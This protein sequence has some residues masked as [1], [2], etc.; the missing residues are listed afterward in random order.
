MAGFDFGFRHS[1]EQADF[2]DVCLS[3]AKSRAR[4]MG[5]RWRV[6][7]EPEGEIWCTVDGNG[8]KMVL[9]GRILE[10]DLPIACEA[11]LESNYPPIKRR[12]IGLGFADL[13]LRGMDTTS[14]DVRDLR[15]VASTHFYF[16]LFELREIVSSGNV[17]ARLAVTEDVL[18]EWA[19]A[20][21]APA[22][23][24]EELHTACELVLQTLVGATGRRLSF[25]ELVDR[26][27]DRSLLDWHTPNGSDPRTLLIELKDFRKH[28]R[29]RAQDGYEQW[30]EEK[31]QEV[32][33][34]LERL[35]RA[36]ER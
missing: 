8:Q 4:Q 1:A 11:L 13:Y 30:L 18:A 17:S 20:Q 32:A 16:P 23:V 2:V 3:I 28:A 26:A 29:H 5:L 19:L 7:R 25:A 10:R 33:E 36:T 22:L 12:R 35:V 31:W 34:V 9:L 15:P 6:S 21:V 14:D 27:A 24:L